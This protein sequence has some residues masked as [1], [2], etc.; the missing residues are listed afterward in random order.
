MANGSNFTSVEFSPTLGWWDGPP[1]KAPLGSI[2]SG[3]NF[4]VRQGRLMPRHPINTLGSNYTPLGIG[5]T[6]ILGAATYIASTWS[7]AGTP[8][9]TPSNVVVPFVFSTATASYFTGSAWTALGSGYSLTGPGHVWGV[10]IYHPPTDDNIFIY[11]T[12]TAHPSV[13]SGILSADRTVRSLSAAPF[14]AQDAVAH[15]HRVLLWNV[16]PAGSGTTR[17]T[18][19]LAWS[20]FNNALDWTGP[21]AGQYDLTDMRGT[22]TRCFVWGNEVVLATTGELWRA[23]PNGRGAYDFS[24]IDRTHGMPYLKAATWTPE[25]IFWLGADLMIYRYAGQSVEPVGGQILHT[26]RSQINPARVDAGDDAFGTQP[27]LGWHDI[28]RHL[29]LFYVDSAHGN[30][31]KTFAYSLDDKIWTPQ[32]YRDIATNALPVLFTRTSN[33]STADRTGSLNLLLSNGTV[34]THYP[35]AAL[36]LSNSG[37]YPTD[38]GSL[39][40]MLAEFPIFTG[41]PTMMKFANEVRFG[42]QATDSVSDAYYLVTLLEN[43][44]DSPASSRR[45]IYAGA[46]YAHAMNEAQIYAPVAGVTG[47]SLVLRFELSGALSGIPLVQPTC[48]HA[49]TN[50]YVGGRYAGRAVGRRQSSTGAS[51]P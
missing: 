9:A 3:M 5:P 40:S 42:V 19:R 41:E 28:G 1:S 12:R 2:T 35:T 25:G 34:A 18:T 44:Q 8:V 14:G 11:G 48:T 32:V 45:S 29:L 21:G 22:G 4:W 30:A 20:A 13:W 33:V 36:D 43:T 27:R 50:M 24:P 15:D 16:R 6:N 7:V 37:V 26:L 31:V 39:N 17:A 38:F 10:S 51:L 46:L 47:N 23:T 49:I